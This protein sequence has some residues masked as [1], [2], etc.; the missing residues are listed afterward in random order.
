MEEAVEWLSGMK[1]VGGGGRG[2]VGA[3]QKRNNESAPEAHR[4]TPDWIF[5]LQGNKQ[6]SKEEK[7]KGRSH[8]NQR[9]C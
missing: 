2:V 9:C 1:C 4:P 7:R 5:M 8:S 3:M 6:T